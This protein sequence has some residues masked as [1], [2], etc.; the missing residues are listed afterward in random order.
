MAFNASALLQMIGGGL[1]GYS[2]GAEVAGA[3]GSG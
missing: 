1:S 2:T 3:G